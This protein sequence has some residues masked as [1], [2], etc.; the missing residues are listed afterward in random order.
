MQKENLPPVLDVCCGSRMMWLDKNDPRAIFG[1]KRKEI[2]TVTDNSK[3]NKS[4]QRVLHINPDVQLDFRD[5]P[6]PDNS[7]SLIAFD[8]P[9]LVHAGKR[10]WLAAKYG[11]LQGDWREDI[12]AGFSEC[13]RVLKPEGT[14]IFKW[15]EVQI[16]LKEILELTPHKPL[17]GQISGAKGMTHWLVFLKT[18]CDTDIPA[19]TDL[20]SN[21]KRKTKKQTEDTSGTEQMQLK[22]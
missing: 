10:S 17:F 12:R 2:I 22:L 20:K 9:H 3:G 4:G 5:L 15:N 8:P 21:R 13:F 11:R 14:L 16:K 7:F 1:D 19:Q 6:Y 18:E